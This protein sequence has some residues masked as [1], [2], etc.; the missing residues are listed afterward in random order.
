MKTNFFRALVALIV[1]TLSAV[2][3]AQNVVKDSV[4]VYDAKA[5]AAYL[6]VHRL[7]TLWGRRFE[8]VGKDS[9]M[10]T[11]RVFVKNNRLTAVNDTLTTRKEVKSVVDTTVTENL[12]KKVVETQFVEK[13]YDENKRD[14]YYANTAE[15][16]IALRSANKYG[17]A[18]GAYAGVQLADHVNSPILGAEASY[19]RSWWEAAVRFEGGQNKLNGNAV[20]AGEKYWNYRTEA[21][22]G[23]QPF[24]FDRWNQNRLFLVGGI[25][26]E[27]YKTDSKE[28][29]GD[30]GEKLEFRSWGNSLYPTAGV[31]YEHR[32]FTTGNT[33]F[34]N[35]QW[36]GLTGVVQNSDA[37]N[38]NAF[39]VTVG[40][41][42]G[43]ARDKVHSVSKNKMRELKK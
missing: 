29:V 22:L 42:F 1:V 27:F 33:L 20:H 37:E 4:N 19:S 23:L 12:Y 40:F 32:F 5:C 10:I 24:K 35:A 43:V 7:D 30:N 25:G 26:F 11:R 18:F 36:R 14:T 17:W 9:L 34:V 13:L 15:G 31:R 41:N 6:N 16:K 3:N 39:V 28:I 8:V 38:Y 21:T 2:A